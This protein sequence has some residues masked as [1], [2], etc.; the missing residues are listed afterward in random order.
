[1][2]KIVNK[3]SS[4][5]I[6]L[7]VLMQ[8]FSLP[9]LL[10]ALLTAQRNSLQE[11]FEQQSLQASYLIRLIIEGHIEQ[12]RLEEI[13]AFFDDLLINNTITYAK[14]KVKNGNSIKGSMGSSLS[15]LKF[16]E[17]D[18]VGS[19]NDSNYFFSTPIAGTTLTKANDQNLYNLRLG[20]SEKN[21]Q[22]SIRDSVFRSIFILIA[23]FIV[24]LLV[25][26]AI[27]KKAVKPI[28]LLR[29]KSHRVANGHFH[30]TLDIKTNVNEIQGLSG[31]LERMR[32]KLVQNAKMLEHLSLHDPLTGL[33][34]RILINDR[35]DQAI[36]EATRSQRE[37]CILMLDLNGFKHVNDSLGHHVGDVVLK[38]T[39]KILSAEIRPYDTVARLGGDEFIIYLKEANLEVAT[40]IAE[41]IQ[42]ALHT[43]FLL[44]GKDVRVQTSI[45]IVCSPDHGHD[46]AILIQKADAAMYHCKE[47]RLKFVIYSEQL[48]RFD[49]Q[50]IELSAD[51][52]NAIN[53]RQLL[54]H[55]QPKVDVTGNGYKV[56]GVE[57]L[58]RWHHP[59]WGLIFPDR[60]VHIA[61]KSG[62]I[63]D[64]TL[65][66]IEKAITD[67]LSCYQEEADF[68]TAINIS[69][70]SLLD[71][72]FVG[73]VMDII[74]RHGV[75]PS[76]LQFE[77]T[78]SEIMN[79]PVSSI[80]ALQLFDREGILIAIDDFGTGYS[81]LSYL[82]ELPI[83]TLKI[84][85]SFITNLIESDHDKAI[86][87]ATIDMAHSL[88]IKVIAEGVESHQCMILL[89]EMNID[90]VQGWYIGKPMPAKQ[91]L[92]WNQLNKRTQFKPT[93]LAQ[94]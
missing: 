13:P 75:D 81:S 21:L 68:S 30:E 61:E 83:S 94:F 54:L 14:L 43:P 45:G 51:L 59:K 85:K 58:V 53:N 46:K 55:Y 27:A 1:M 23:Y 91:L 25:T 71:Q 62:L 12:Q 86:V 2:N 24:S 80:D 10:Y 65:W 19:N 87:K 3:F 70:V 78:E 6:I 89:S 11:E 15:S 28:G 76:R 90:S 40:E 29:Q 26:Y 73:A 82:K 93:L 67:N 56:V 33:P 63:N 38:Q 72:D 18:E 5:L 52:V 35:L 32:D 9:L 64:L 49:A 88:G 41:R 4:R 60:F 34:N 42:A 22:L 37:F 16:Q 47:K 50:Y 31:D 84:D 74:R 66:I 7:F 44:D 36:L 17:D 69:A 39:A 92:Q 77:L 8:V 20:F 57:A 48:H 79:D